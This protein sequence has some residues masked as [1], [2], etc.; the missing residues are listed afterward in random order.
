MS[1]NDPTY[2]LLTGSGAT[3]FLWNPLVT[4]IVLH[5]CRALPIELPGHG[6]K[7]VFPPGYAIHRTS[8]NSPRRARRWRT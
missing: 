8:T 6:F 3:S 4:E 1:S 7:T 5:G 2:L